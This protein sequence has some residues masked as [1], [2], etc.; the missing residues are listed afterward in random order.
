MPLGIPHSAFL[1]WD[2]DDQDLA[3]AWNLYRASGCPQCGLHDDEWRDERGR[4]V[5][6]P[7]YEVVTLRCAWCK[8]MSDFK[9]SSEIKDSDT[10]SLRFG[11]KRTT[12]DEEE[13][14]DG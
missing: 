3:L 1:A 4:D 5:N 9:R 2:E 10:E 6:P 12:E 14:D 11:W 8:A 7:P 13:E